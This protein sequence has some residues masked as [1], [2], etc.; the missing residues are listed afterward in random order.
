[1]INLSQMTKSLRHLTAL[2]MLNS[3]LF[4]FTILISKNIN[5][6]SFLLNLFHIINPF[7]IILQIF[8]AYWLAKRWNAKHQQGTGNVGDLSASNSQ[9]L[10]RPGPS[11]SFLA[12]LWSAVF[13]G[14]TTTLPVVFL[15]LFMLASMGEGPADVHEEVASG[16]FGFILGICVLALMLAILSIFASVHIKLQLHRKIAKAEEARE[17]LSESERMAW[18]FSRVV[19]F[20]IG[21]AFFVA[22]FITVNYELL[23]RGY[24]E[25]RSEKRNAQHLAFIKSQQERHQQAIETRQRSHLAAIESFHKEHLKQTERSVFNSVFGHNIDPKVLSGIYSMADSARFIRRSFRMSFD[26]MPLTPAEQAETEKQGHRDI[27]RVAVNVSYALY[28]NSSAPEVFPSRAGTWSPYFENALQLAGLPDKFTKLSI[29]GGMEREGY[30][31]NGNYGEEDFET[32]PVGVG[33]VRQLKLKQGKFIVNSGDQ[34]VRISYTYEIKKKCH[35]SH[36]WVSSR[37]IDEMMISAHDHSMKNLGFHLEPISRGNA[38]RRDVSDIHNEWYVGE[39]TLANQGII[40]YW[41]PQKNA[42]NMVEDPKSQDSNVQ[43]ASVKE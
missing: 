7:Q 30:L 28:N 24:A 33:V 22:V 36:S 23:L 16:A 31:R 5:R 3:F 12:R 37:P 40:L 43:R 21:M 1:M 17:P 35:D 2:T 26:F 42:K 27:V 13:L 19:V 15:A 39:P 10:N 9:F 25:Q 11:S 34:P 4:M 20:E 18:E 14:I 6:G 8:L 29:A 41:L 32:E 38:S